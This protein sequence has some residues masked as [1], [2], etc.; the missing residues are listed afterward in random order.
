MEDKHENIEETPSSSDLKKHSEEIK[1]LLVELQT[2]YQ[3]DNKAVA[4]KLGISEGKLNKH[5]NESIKTDGPLLET[6]SSLRELKDNLSKGNASK[7]GSINFSIE[8]LKFLK[9]CTFRKNLMWILM[10]L[11]SI[12]LA[13]F[14]PWVFAFSPIV[15]ESRNYS[16]ILLGS[17]FNLFITLLACVIL[18]FEK[19]PTS[20]KCSEGIKKSMSSFLISWYLTWVSW[21]LLFV[22]LSINLKAFGGKNQ[23]LFAVADVLNLSSSI[24]LFATFSSLYFKSIP[25]VWILTSFILFIIFGVLAILDCYL[26]INPSFRVHTVFS[27]IAGVALLFFVGRLDSVHIKIKYK[28]AFLFCFYLY[29]LIQLG[30]DKLDN[31]VLLIAGVSKIFLGVFVGYSLLSEDKLENY[32]SNIHGKS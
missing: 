4:D 12:L 22:V 28:L 16:D 19:I 8:I 25:R 20:W 11:F 14:S 10:G 18:L 1:E 6:L 23:A 32:F 30:W 21:F 9:A 27:Y 29:A 13:F 17:G 31:I 5:K 2:N 3:L 7:S 26:I 24:C 15:D